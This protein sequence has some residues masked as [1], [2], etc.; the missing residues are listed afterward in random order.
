MAHRAGPRL[1]GIRRGDSVTP[2]QLRNVDAVRT[3]AQRE[4]DFLAKE[5]KAMEERLDRE[6]VAKWLASFRTRR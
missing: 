5:R 2:A 4:V 3:L 1:R 6:A